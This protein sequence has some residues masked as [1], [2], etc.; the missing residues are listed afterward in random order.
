MKT[1]ILTF[2]TSFILFSNLIGQWEIVNE[3]IGY[4]LHTIDFINDDIGWI[5]AGNSIYKT[6]DGGKNWF[7]LWKDESRYFCRI[8]FINDSV[9]WAIDS[10]NPNAVI[11]KT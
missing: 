2:I 10:N 11:F 6:I 7:L 9:G 1:I 3:G 5:A 4:E 8:D